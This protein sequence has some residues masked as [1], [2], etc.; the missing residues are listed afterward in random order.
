MDAIS[1][2]VRLG[3][4]QKL[5]IT[6]CTYK[7]ALLKVAYFTTVTVAFSPALTCPSQLGSGTSANEGTEGGAE[8]GGAGIYKWVYDVKGERF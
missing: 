3:H 4:R 8:G 6:S 2:C 1:L 5:H 7:P